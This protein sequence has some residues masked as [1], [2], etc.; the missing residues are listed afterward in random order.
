MNLKTKKVQIK[1]SFDKYEIHKIVIYCYY[2]CAVVIAQ[3]EKF[4]LSY[5]PRKIKEILYQ[6][7]NNGIAFTS[8]YS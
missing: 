7:D 5:K 8:K 3:S 4:E 2:V 6:L 1:G